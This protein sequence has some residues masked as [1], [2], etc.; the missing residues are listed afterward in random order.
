MKILLTGANGI[1]G[2]EL[3]KSLVN[4]KIDLLATGRGEF[5]HN[6]LIINN[7]H[8]YAELEL[9]NHELLE[10]T[11]LSFQPTHILHLAAITQVD[12]CEVNKEFCYSINTVSSQL[13]FKLAKKIGAKVFYLSTDFVF[14]GESGPYDEG[15][16]TSP[17]NYYGFTKMTS[18]NL[19]RDSGADY[20]IIR[21]VLLYG[22]VAASTRSN[23]IHWVK[24]NLENNMPIKVVNDQ[25]R[26]PT[27]IPDLVK[28]IILAIE[29]NASGLFH[30]SGGE[31]LTPYEMA[32]SIATFL[33]LD[34]SLITAVN[35]STF[36]QPAKR[37]LKTGF[38]ISKA[39]NTLGYKPTPFGKALVEIFDHHWF[40]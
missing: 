35:A 11:I 34:K 4:K 16:P 22:K 20:C 10:K 18:E 9:S 13:I 38:D 5:R 29:S 31:T 6:G 1:L 39:M 28:G 3:L 2:V 12:D 17:I 32:I 36:S 15:N 21:T 33:N 19:L 40:S 23:F 14:D 30:I 24:Q 37:P 8:S 25:V 26:T 7:Q 27:Y